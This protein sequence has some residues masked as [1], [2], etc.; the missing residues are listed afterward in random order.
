L[1]V[2][3]VAEEEEE[4]CREVKICIAPVEALGLI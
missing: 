3:V 4:N 2:L 1:P